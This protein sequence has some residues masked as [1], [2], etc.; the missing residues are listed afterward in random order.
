MRSHVL[1][2][3]PVRSYALAN[4]VVSCLVRV[5]TSRKDPNKCVDH[6]QKFT[7][8]RMMRVG[9]SRPLSFAFVFKH[10]FRRPSDRGR[11]MLIM[12]TT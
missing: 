9:N 6:H 7:L 4:S 5:S 1:K 12:S 11:P 3:L 8:Q 10:A 2:E